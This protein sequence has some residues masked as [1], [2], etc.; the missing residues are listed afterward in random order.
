MK[1]VVYKLDCLETG[2]IYI[3]SSV[4]LKRRI[5]RGWE[6]QL[7]DTFVRS[8]PIVVE[9]WEG[10][11]VEELR[12]REQYHIER[13]PCVNRIMAHRSQEY[14]RKQK[15]AEYHRNKENRRAN[16]KRRENRFT[17]EFCKSN[18]RWDYR[19]LHFKISNRCIEARNL[20]IGEIEATFHPETQPNPAQNNGGGLI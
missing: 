5:R 18:I 2:D 9:K 20:K 17:C 7:P 1:G 10:T 6:G 15:L 8:A 16:E 14:A 13:N 4:S 19:H 11:D 3:G 12:K